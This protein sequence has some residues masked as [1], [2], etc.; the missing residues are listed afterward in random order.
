[1]GCIDKLNTLRDLRVFPDDKG[2]LRRIAY[3]MS[4]DGKAPWQLHTDGGIW[5]VSKYAFQDTFRTDS[6]VRLPKKYEKI[7]ASLGIDWEKITRVDLEIPIISAVAARLYLSNFAESIP[8]NYAIEEQADYW[9]KFYMKDHESKR[10]MNRN[11]FIFDVAT[12]NNS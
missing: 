5:Q 2:F 1:M 6:H 12:L 9:W 7:K 10:H 3:V 8:P 11:D 4:R